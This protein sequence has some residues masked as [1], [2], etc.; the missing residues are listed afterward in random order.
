M[1]VFEVE[2]VYITFRESEIHQ[3]KEEI[4]VIEEENLNRKDKISR[5]TISI[6]SLKTKNDSLS[7]IYNYKHV[8]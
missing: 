3:I 4:S 6:N 1:I 8:M 7:G 2:I 5:T